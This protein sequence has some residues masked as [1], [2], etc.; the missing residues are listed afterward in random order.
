MTNQPPSPRKEAILTK[1]LFKLVL[2]LTD[3]KPTYSAGL[4]CI[5]WPGPITLILIFI[6]S[7]SC[8]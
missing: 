7:R 2:G 4:P 1:A 3:N 8:E 6:V 5:V